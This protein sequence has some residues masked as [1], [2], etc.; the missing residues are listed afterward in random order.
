[1]PRRDFLKMENSL[2]LLEYNSKIKQLVHDPD[3]QGCW[4]TAET[5]DLRV[6][7]GHCYLEKKQK[8]EDGATVARLGF[9]K[10]KTVP[11]WRG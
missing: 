4:V 5:S 6:S 10:M 2:T 1:M 8:N 11:L 7:R 9:R 3:V